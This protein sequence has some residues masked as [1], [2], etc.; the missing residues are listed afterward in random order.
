[1]NRQPLVSILIPNYNYGH[2]LEQC[3]NS[4]LNQTYKNIELVFCDNNSVDNSY[5]IAIRYEKIFNEK[6]MHF[7]LMKNKKNIGSARNSARCYCQSE[8]DFIIFLSS[9]DFIEATFIEKCVSIMEKNQ[10]V[11]MVMVH[12]NEVDEKG[13]IFSTMPFYN[14]SCIIL[15]EEQAA[16]FMMAGIAIPSQ[17]LIRKSI[18]EKSRAEA[19]L[20]F[21]IAGDWFNNFL[22]SIYSD[23]AYIMEP[24]CNY[25]IHSGNETSSSEANLLGIFEH[26]QLINQFISLAK[27]HKMIKPIERYDEAVIKLGSM[28]LR[29]ALKMFKCGRNDAARRYLQLA[30][31]FKMDIVNDEVYSKFLTYLYLDENELQEELQLFEKNNP[32]GRV[33]S[34]DPPE[35]YIPILN[36]K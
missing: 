5:E 19:A 30:P 14:K 13:E 36:D 35:G 12:R 1:M 6:G 21:Q 23:V 26:Y 18:Y 4:V 22:V 29:Y 10:Y 11:G 2:Y 33:V 7:Q 8:G 17:I 9:D 31:V 34:Y 32:M 28:C 3:L 24:L 15:G 16:V 20:G 25:R 27:A